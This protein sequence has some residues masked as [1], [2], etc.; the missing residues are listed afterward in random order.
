MGRFTELGR[1]SLRNRWEILHRDATFLFFPLPNLRI[2]TGEERVLRL[3]QTVLVIPRV[4]ALI[5]HP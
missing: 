2:I 1:Q 5:H 3:P 4:H